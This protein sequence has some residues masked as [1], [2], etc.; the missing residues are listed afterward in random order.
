M[1]DAFQTPSAMFIV[2]EYPSGRDLFFMIH[3]R[4]ALSLFQTRAFVV[5][6]VLAPTTSTPRVSSIAT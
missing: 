3:E 6:V 2:M 4:G 5:Q 1:L